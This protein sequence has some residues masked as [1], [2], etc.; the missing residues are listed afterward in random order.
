MK[1]SEVVH[2][3]AELVA[4]H[5]DLDC[6]T[7]GGEPVTVVEFNDDMSAENSDGPEGTVQPPVFIVGG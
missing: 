1:A 2:H 6:E 5:G 4:Q 7:D 3:L